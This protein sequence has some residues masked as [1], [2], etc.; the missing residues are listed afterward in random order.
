MTFSVALGLG[1]CVGV[2]PIVTLGVG[3]L[4]IVGVGL[5]VNGITSVGQLNVLQLPPN[6][7]GCAIPVYPNICS[8][9][10]TN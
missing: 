5:G 4:V 3:V 6:I 8:T 2:E 10:I 9:P 7:V 1:V